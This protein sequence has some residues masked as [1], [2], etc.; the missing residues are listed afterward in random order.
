MPFFTSL[1]FVRRQSSSN[2][3]PR[4]VQDTFQINP[5][6]YTQACTFPIALQSTTLCPTSQG[7]YS[8]TR[9]RC[10]HSRTSVPDT[11]VHCSSPSRP[12]VGQVTVGAVQFVHPEVVNSE[13]SP[14]PCKF[15][16]T[17]GRSRKIAH[18][19]Y[20]VLAKLPVGSLSPLHRSSATGK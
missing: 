13:K 17:A 7:D 19:S 2:L 8:T 18:A 14:R 9:E 6:A 12:S 1:V 11:S 15:P 10:Y 4:R 5:S 3:D 20:S 16:P